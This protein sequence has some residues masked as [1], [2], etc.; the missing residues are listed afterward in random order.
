M[1]AT[2]PA[3]SFTV[4]SGRQVLDVLAGNETGVIDLVR[5]TYLQHAAGD[6]VNPPSY[7]LRFPDRPSARIIALPASIGSARGVDGIK[8]ISS[9]PENLGRGMPRASAVVILNDPVTGFPYA[10]LESSWISA[11]RTA[12]SAALAAEVLTG[13]GERPRSVGFVGAGLI[14]RSVHRYLVRSGWEFDRVGVYDVTPDHAHRFAA[15]LSGTPRP[16]TVQIHASAGEAVQA[17]DLVVFATVAPAPHVLDPGLFAHHPLVLHLSLRDLGTA[18][19][20]G[21]D[22]VVDDADHCLRAETSVHLAEQ[23]V[24]DRRFLTGTLADVMSG[25]VE[26]PRGRTVV[27]SPFGLGVLDLAVAKAV[28][29]DLAARAALSPVPGFFTDSDDRA[30]VA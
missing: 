8:W 10:C 26:R 5:E 12:A 6:T 2:P 29:D 24:G 7:F 14:A 21:A 28:H 4:I 19:I 13:D 25:V 3:P 30:T 15:S 11:A 27:F 17:H 9:V 1:R 22:N 23:Q 20:L 16:A 18:V